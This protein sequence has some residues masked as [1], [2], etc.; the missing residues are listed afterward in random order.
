M[1]K[2]DISAACATWAMKDLDC[3][4][5]GC[6]GFRFKLPQ[7]FAP[8]LYARPDPTPFVVTTQFS[9]QFPAPG[10]EPDNKLGGQCYYDPAN[11]PVGKACPSP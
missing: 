8:P 2:D 11:A 1:L 5:K 6:F 9:T 3:P 10:P 7:G 4:P